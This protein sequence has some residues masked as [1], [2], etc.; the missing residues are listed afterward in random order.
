VGAGREV[1]VVTGAS[2]GIGAATAERLAGGGRRLVLGARRLEQ[3]EALAE[4]LA[5]QHGAGALGLQLDVTDQASVADFARR[6]EDFAGEQGVGVLVNNAGKAL[7][8]TPLPDAGPADV[9]DWRSMLDT[10]VLGLLLVTHAF[11][12]GLL[13]CNRGHIVNVGSLA[14]LETYEGG[15]VYCATKAAVRVISRGLRLELLGRALKV[16]CI[17]P[18]MVETEFS[19]VRLGD[20]QKAL[21][22]Y[23]GMTPLTADDVARAIEWVVDLPAHVSVEELNVQP[24]DQASARRVHRRA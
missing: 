9:A 21:A 19:V 8:V 2:S 11:L 12:P 23:A 10:N 20:E 15:A 17:N 5:A 3:V 7:G 24:S 6:A 16:T 4:R 18:G 1:A 14:G 13:A 22:V